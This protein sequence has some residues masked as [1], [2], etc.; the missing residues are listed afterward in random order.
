VLPRDEAHSEPVHEKKA[1]LPTPP[2]IICNTYTFRSITDKQKRVNRYADVRGSNHI[3]RKTAQGFDGS[4]HA[5][6]SRIYST[7]KQQDSETK[8]AAEA[9][10]LPFPD[11]STP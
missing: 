8:R 7:K 6:R 3:K 10:L 4:E 11:Y 9:L 1:S 5:D 2:T